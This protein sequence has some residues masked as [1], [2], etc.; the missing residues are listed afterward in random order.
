MCQI[1]RCTVNYSLLFLLFIE[2][3][4]VLAVAPFKPEFICENILQRLIK[5]N[6]IVCLR[7]VDPSSSECY[8]YRCGKHCDYF[9]MILQGR[10]QVEFGK[11]TLVFEGGP[12][13]YFG[14]QALGMLWCFKQSIRYKKNLACLCKNDKCLLHCFVIYFAMHKSFSNLTDCWWHTDHR[15]LTSFNIEMYICIQHWHYVMWHIVMLLM[16]Y[17]YWYR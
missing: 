12:F 17:S 14:A 10:V 11:E 13:V 4:F 5:Q 8:L 16:H 3:C 15:L 1:V 7:L 2:W 9:I 6:V